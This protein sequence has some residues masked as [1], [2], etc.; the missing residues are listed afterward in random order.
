[1]P[2]KLTRKISPTFAPVFLR[3][4]FSRHRRF[5]SPRSASQS[6]PSTLSAQEDCSI[7]DGEPRILYPV[8][9]VA[10]LVAVAL[11]FFAIASKRQP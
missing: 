11:V 9:Y 1:M 3:K 6:A 5:E 4:A 7:Q 2:T 10:V 8:I